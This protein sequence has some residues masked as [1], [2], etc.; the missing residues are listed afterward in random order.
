MAG[1][2]ALGPRQAEPSVVAVVSSRRRRDAAG[3]SS[4]AATPA[5][6]GFHPL[7]QRQ[8]MRKRPTSALSRELES[9]ASAHRGP[10]GSR[11]WCGRVA[12]VRRLAGWRFLVAVFTQS[13]TESGARPVA[14]HNLHGKPKGRARP[15]LPLRSETSQSSLSVGARTENIVWTLQIPTTSEDRI[16]SGE[17]IGLLKYVSLCNITEI[18]YLTEDPLVQAGMA[19]A[20]MVLTIF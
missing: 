16:V 11:R 1:G 3:S 12:G 15:E 8:S 20:P 18:L 6:E 7:R 2:A 17:L 4:F 5:D 10:G 19:S 13:L 14:V 9:P